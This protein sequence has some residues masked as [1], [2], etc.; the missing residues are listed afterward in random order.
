MIQV[1][2]LNFLGE[3][4]CYLRWKH[5][6][7]IIRPI[8]LSTEHI[9]CETPPHE[10]ANMS[11]ELMYKDSVNT[12]AYV[13]TKQLEYTFD[14]DPH[15]LQLSPAHITLRADERDIVVKVN[16]LHFRNTSL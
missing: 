9:L 14:P 11:F 10:P 13:T 1:K 15:I 12:T 8:M 4:L 7:I 2:G 3:A 6:E 5:E 16:G